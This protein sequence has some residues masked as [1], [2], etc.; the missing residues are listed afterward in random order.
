MTHYLSQYNFVIKYNPD[1]YNTEA[2]CLSRNPVYESHE[3]KEDNLRTV[4]V[5]KIEEI[6]DVQNKTSNIKNKHSFIRESGMYY[7]RSN[8]KNKLILSEEYSKILIKKLD[9]HFCLIGINQ[10]ESKIRTFYTAP[11]RLDKIKLICRQCEVCIKNKTQL[12]RKYGLMSQLGPA[13]KPFQIISIDTIGGFGSNR[14]SKKYLHLL[15]DH[16]TRYAYISYSKTQLA[17]DFIKLVDQVLKNNKVE[18]LLSDQYP[19]LKSKEFKKY[20]KDH[21]VDLI[22]TAV[23]APFSNGHNEKLNQTL[24]NR[25][26][27]ALNSKKRMAWT[28]VA[29]DCVKAYNSTN[30]TVTGYSPISV[31]WRKN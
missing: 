15:M 26:R 23:D 27:C 6:L 4:N 29:I 24:V 31:K 22:F 20:L 9:E 8:K 14:S 2:E 28:T 21:S 11:N 30:H 17:K 5:I 16:F 1:R 25:I 18:I 10:I 19:A 13:D 3:N 12:N 7:K